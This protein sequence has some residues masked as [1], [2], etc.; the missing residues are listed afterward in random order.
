MYTSDYGTFLGNCERERKDM[1]LAFRTYS[2]WSF[3]NQPD[4]MKNY[5]NIFYEPNSEP[6][7]PSISPFSLELWSNLYLRF[8]I[9]QSAAGEAKNQ[10]IML[11][12]K[13]NE[14]KL[15]VIKLRK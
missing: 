14:L 10:M 15:K 3:I 11:K 8:Q 9:D 5:I 12:E 6:I 7:W 4:V 13:E 1:Q 2:L